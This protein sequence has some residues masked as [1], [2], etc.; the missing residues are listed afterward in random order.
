MNVIESLFNTI[1]RN[2]D[3]TADY[4]N[5]LIA[6]CNERVNNI[7]QKIT[8]IKKSATTQTDSGL[9]PKVATNDLVKKPK[10]STEIQ[11]QIIESKFTYYP[12]QRSPADP[13]SPPRNYFHKITKD[14]KGNV[15]FT[16]TFHPNGISLSAKEFSDK[17][18]N[19]LSE[20]V[21]KNNEGFWVYLCKVGPNEEYRYMSEVDDCQE[22]IDRVLRLSK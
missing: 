16:N 14:V 11:G 5:S 19:P 7:N 8:Q 1:P 10:A 22:V 20:V 15:T 17:F 2:M 9:P 13:I 4:A 6:D 18:Y 12:V 3:R 21:G